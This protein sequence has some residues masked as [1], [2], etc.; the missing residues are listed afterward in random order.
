MK[1]AILFSLMLACS[2]SIF[3]QY[4][5]PDRPKLVVGIVVDQMRVDYLYRYWDQLGNDGFKRMIG[6]GHFLRNAHYNYMSTLTGPGH[7]S[8][9]TGTTPEHHGII[10]N[11]WF[12]R[13]SGKYTY[14][15][16]DTAVQGVGHD[17]Y[18]GQRSP[19]WL[20][21]TTIAEELELATNRRSKTIGVASK[22]R[23]SILPNGRIGD[24]AFWYVGGDEG[25]YISSTWYMEE[26]PSWLKKFNKQKLPHKYLKEDWETLLPIEEYTQS[27]PDDNPYETIY[28]TKKRPVFPYDLSKIKKEKG[29]LD[30][31][32]YIPMGNSLTVDMAIAAIDGEEMGKDADCDMLSLSFSATDKV[33]HYFGVTAVETQDTYLR[34]DLEI[35]RLL[36]HLDQQVGNGE[37]LV[38]LTADHGGPHNPNY[39]KDEGG[40]AGFIQFVGVK[41]V[42]QETLEKA[43]GPG[44]WVL[45]VSNEQ[46]YLN[47]EYIHQRGLDLARSQQMVADALVGMDGIMKAVSATTLNTTDYN[48]GVMQLVQNGFDQERSGDVMFVTDPGFY[49]WEKWYKDKGSDHRSPWNY[50]THIPIIFYGKGVK[51]GSSVREVNITDIA[52]TVSMML[53]IMEPNACT[54]KVIPE[55]IAP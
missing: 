9:H 44:Q 53:G 4:Q 36:K 31:V 12:L 43:H 5:G 51:V 52:P 22:D 38:F 17:S 2:S 11:D 27:L 10:A 20:R 55:V 24:A 54:G 1:K 49:P 3:A 47:R 8:V 6:N 34:L 21:S 33:G 46:V 13:S 48:D 19:V 26:L 37:Y 32:R 35:A 30:L 15:A 14:C 45:G 16:E 41:T 40:S 42:A 7:A 25:K 29:N 28:P 23:G 39:I 50:D 18:K